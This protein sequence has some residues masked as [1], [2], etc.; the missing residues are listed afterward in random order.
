[1]SFDRVARIY[2]ATRG[3]PADV[4]V[5]VTDAVLAAVAA[6]PATRF[7]EVG[8]GTGRIGLPI[9]AR[10]VSYTGVDISVEMLAVLQQKAEE[11][12]VERNL[13]L[14][15][16]DITALP[17]G[18][19]EFDVVLGV[20]IFHLIAEWQRAI[21]EARRVLR[22][23]GFLV[24]G[25]NHAFPTEPGEAIQRQ[26]LDFAR[27]LGAPVRPENG[28][29]ERVEALLIE[30]GCFPALY[31]AAH[32]S[33]SLRPID[34]MESERDRTYSH[35]WSVPDD[36]LATLHEQVLGWGQE[37]FGD[38]TLSLPTRQEFQLLVCS[39]PDSVFF[40]TA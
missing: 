10:G 18:D 3:L 35:S 26:W 4:S 24:L 6:T 8:I 32:W 13:H 17:F 36:M 22:P 37:T 40:E 30:S 2:D 29:W 31:R 5:Q 20:H 15:R 16:G 12:A 23:G 21:E 28:S 25:G 19:D 1:M 14:V 39:W 9:A 7:L 38:L 33:G 34:L 27:A 11:A